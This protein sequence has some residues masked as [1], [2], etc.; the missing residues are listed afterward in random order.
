MIVNFNT[1]FEENLEIVYDRKR[2]AHEYIKTRFAVDF[3]S[4][5]PID[6]ISKLFFSTDNEKFKVFSLLKLIRMLRLTRII[7]VLNVQRD[8]KSKIKLFQV[9]FQLT[10]YLHCQAC[11]IWFMIEYDKIWYHPV[12]VGDVSWDSKFYSDSKLAQYV[13]SFHWSLLS[14]L[15]NDN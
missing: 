5:I 7:R 8:A 9:F 2:I 12:L 11:L 14:M 6:L 13:N 4:A 3:L 1:T 10:L 15:G